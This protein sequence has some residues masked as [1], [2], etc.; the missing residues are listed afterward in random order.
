MTCFI[1]QHTSLYQFQM[2]L[3]EY[4]SE[5]N[6]FCWN[7]IPMQNSGLR[8]FYVRFVIPSI[9]AILVYWIPTRNPVQKELSGI[10]LKLILENIYKIFYHY[11]F[12]FLWFLQ[13]Q[14]WKSALSERTITLNLTG[15]RAHEVSQVHLAFQSEIFCFHG[16]NSAVMCIFHSCCI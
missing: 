6:A 7:C 16:P 8:K 12:L 3:E 9:K 5:N 13:L 4:V 10:I 2:P 15:T 14:L 11:T 1:P